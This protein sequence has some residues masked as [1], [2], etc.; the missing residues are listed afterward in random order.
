MSFSG[1]RVPLLQCRLSSSVRADLHQSPCPGFLLKGYQ[2]GSQA[3]RTNSHG[4]CSHE[5]ASYPCGKV[6]LG[7]KNIKHCEARIQHKAL[8]GT[9]LSCSPCCCHQRAERPQV[10]HVR[11]LLIP[12][13][14]KIIKILGDL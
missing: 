11:L 14:D 1:S 5:D 12:G 9:G 2:R 7:I 6:L 3:D 8:L 4:T 10:H 13:V